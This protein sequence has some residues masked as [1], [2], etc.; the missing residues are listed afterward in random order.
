MADIVLLDA[1]AIIERL[2]AAAPGFRAF[3]GAAELAAALE[4]L[5]L[6]PAAFVIPLGDQVGANILA[7]E[8]VEQQVTTRFGVVIAVQNLKD[9]T[10][11][12]AAKDLRQLRLAVL[13]A[14]LRWTPDAAQYS[15]FEWAAGRLILLRDR[16]LYW[17]DDYRTS[18]HVR[19][20]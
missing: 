7:T 8:S 4:N 14:L 11:R 15:P 9:T 12:Q 5:K 1:E 17:Q 19:A 10:G 3:N 13:G 6:S 20:L 18:S 2:Q 16:V